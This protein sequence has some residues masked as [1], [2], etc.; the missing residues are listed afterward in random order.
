MIKASWVLLLVFM[1][2]LFLPRVAWAT[3]DETAT[4]SYSYNNGRLKIQFV[5]D[6]DGI[7]DLRIDRH[8]FKGPIPMSEATGSGQDKSYTFY[9]ED[10]GISRTITLVV[11]FDVDS[12]VKA[13]SAFYYEKSSG[14]AHM[15]RV[16]TFSPKFRR[17]DIEA[18]PS[19]KDRG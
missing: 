16:V 13:V 17:I 12:A 8:T 10:R 11:L 7:R 14:S 4:G 5:L 9:V 6:L 19:N 2:S 18:L 3:A 15:K 1:L